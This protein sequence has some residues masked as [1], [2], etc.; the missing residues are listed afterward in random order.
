MFFQIVNILKAKNTDMSKNIGAWDLMSS[1][2]KLYLVFY[3]RAAFQ[4][5]RFFAADFYPL[6]LLFFYLGFF[7]RTFTNHRTAGEGGGYLFNSSPPLTH[8]SQ[9]LRHWPCDYR[10]E[11]TSARNLQPDSNREPLIL[12]RKSLTTKLRA[13][14]SMLSF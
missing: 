6:C 13:L 2:L 9:T 10:R 12:E 1:V 7:S 4:V 11:L 8:T 5:L 14:T 3:F